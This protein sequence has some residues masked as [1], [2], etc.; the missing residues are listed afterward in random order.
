MS[1]SVYAGAASLM[2]AENPSEALPQN[3][4]AGAYPYLEALG[5]HAR[6]CEREQSTT[7]TDRL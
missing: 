2:P 1:A 6:C 5:E 7:P 4:K 3:V